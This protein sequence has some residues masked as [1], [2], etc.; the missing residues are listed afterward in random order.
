MAQY[1]VVDHFVIVLQPLTGAAR[2]FHF[3]HG[4]TKAAK[5]ALVAAAQARRQSER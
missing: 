5:V 1:D 2:V 4:W 3:R